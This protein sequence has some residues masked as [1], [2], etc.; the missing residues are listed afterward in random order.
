[1]RRA[2]WPAGLLLSV[3][4]ALLITLLGPLALFNPLFTGALQ[5]RHDVPARLGTSMDEVNRATA[6][7]LGDVVF[8]GD[9]GTMLDG[10]EPVLDA[11]ERSH[12]QD[13]S[14][15]VRLLWLVVLLAIAVT[16]VT[17]VLLRRE[18]ERIGRVLLVSSGAVGLTAIVLA[19]TFALAFDS[20]FTAFHEIFFPPGTWQF[21]PE[22]DLIRF[23][24]QPFWF[25]AALAAGA[26]IVVAAAIVALIG[27]RLARRRPPPAR[28]A[29]AGAG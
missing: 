16:V 22:S 4:V 20:A 26:T 1:M 8:G 18:R 5:E 13:V 25:D 21:G 2:P 27:W 15:L 11:Y 24:P 28:P 17:V 10:E 9:F 7:M 29:V 19:A 14:R 3:A 12:M 6:E 23:F